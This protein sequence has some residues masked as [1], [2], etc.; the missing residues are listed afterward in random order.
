MTG[1]GDAGS[2]GEGTLPPLARSPAAGAL[3]RGAHGHCR[4][5]SST[6]FATLARTGGGTVLTSSHSIWPRRS[7]AEDTSPGG[8]DPQL[9]RVPAAEETHRLTAAPRPPSRHAPWR[10]RAEPRRFGNLTPQR[11]FSQAPPPE[12]RRECWLL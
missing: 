12:A 9:V 1:Y 6:L 7:P 4:A 2:G 3:T 10:E 5:R 11:L 8:Q